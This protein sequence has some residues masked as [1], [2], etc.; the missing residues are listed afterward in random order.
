MDAGSEKGRHAC[1][2]A[3]RQ[4]AISEPLMIPSQCVSS[5][6][7]PHA[8]GSCNRVWEVSSRLPERCASADALSRANPSAQ[9]VPPVQL[10]GSRYDLQHSPSDSQRPPTPIVQLHGLKKL[11]FGL[12]LYQLLPRLLTQT[13]QWCGRNKRGRTTRLPRCLPRVTSVRVPSPPP[14]RLRH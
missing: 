6:V 14:P 1:P 12:A 5:P 13:G 2:D 11:H 4:W 10:H 3:C 9:R 7:L 8:Y